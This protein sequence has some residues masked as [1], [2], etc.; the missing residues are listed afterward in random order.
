[1]MCDPHSPSSE[2][3]NR[4]RTEEHLWHS[5]EKEKQQKHAIV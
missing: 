4:L 3:E 5:E 1:M 2:E